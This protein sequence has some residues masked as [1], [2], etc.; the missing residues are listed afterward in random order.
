MERYSKGNINSVNK[1][2]Q[3]GSEKQTRSTNHRIT[4]CIAKAQT[5]VPSNPS[6]K[7]HWRRD[8]KAMFI[9]T[10]SFLLHIDI[11]E[12]SYHA[13]HFIVTRGRAWFAW[14]WLFTLTVKTQTSSLFSQSQKS[15][16]NQCPSPR[17]AP[18]ILLCSFACVLTS[19]V[20]GS[21]SPVKQSKSVCWTGYSLVSEDAGAG[22][23]HSVRTAGMIK[24]ARCCSM[25]LRQTSIIMWT[26]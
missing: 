6:A 23:K 7:H 26:I 17:P 1:R 12:T 9:Q 5:S 4:S 10:L 14:A 8:K 20:L 24:E 13:F 3:R 2:L 16:V 21:K 15:A 11:W 25:G 19:S 18:N 22:G